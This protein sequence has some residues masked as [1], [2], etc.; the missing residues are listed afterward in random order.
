[1]GWY[2]NYSPNRLLAFVIGLIIVFGVPAGSLCGLL[3]ARYPLIDGW[4]PS[5][6]AWTAT[7]VLPLTIVLWMRKT[8]RDRWLLRRDIAD[9]ATPERA[10]DI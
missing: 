9:R 7:T 5:A 6:I 10:Q 8:G 1:M 2:A 4:V 3:V